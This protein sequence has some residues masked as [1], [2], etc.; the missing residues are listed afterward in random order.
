M[1]NF[2]EDGS[3]FCRISNISILK[4]AQEEGNPRGM[5]TVSLYNRKSQILKNG[6]YYWLHALVNK[7]ISRKTQN[8]DQ[9]SWN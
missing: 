8:D 7:D 9:K 3:I 2:Y 1:Y 4:R 6:G 5:S